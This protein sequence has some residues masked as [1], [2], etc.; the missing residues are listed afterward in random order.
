MHGHGHHKQQEHRVPLAPKPTRLLLQ[1]S[2]IQCMADGQVW[3]DS[4]R[5]YDA[6]MPWE[7]AACHDAMMGGEGWP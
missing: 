3:V 4:M 1:D 2:A 6:A 5:A 7:R